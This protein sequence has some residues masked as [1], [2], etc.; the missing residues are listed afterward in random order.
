MTLLKKMQADAATY[1]P[2]DIG[3][4][5]VDALSGKTFT[6][7]NPATGVAL[8]EVAEGDALD[9]EAAVAAAEKAA[10]IWGA[11][12]PLQRAEI[13]NRAADI[14]K[15][16]MPEFVEV[17]V[18]QTG[19]PVREMKAQLARTPEWYSYFA[20]VAR[21][22]ETSSPPFGGHYLNY[23]RRMPIGVVG[24]VTPWN[25]PLLILTKKLAPALAAGN[26]VVVKPSE[27]APITPMMLADVLRDA[28]LPDG[29]YNVVPGFG[30]TAG[31]ALCNHDRIGKLD[32][33][34]G[35]ETGRMVAAIAGEKLIPFS[36]ELGGKASVIV[37][38]DVLESDA[39]AAALFASF[40]AAGQTCVQGARLLVQ[41]SVHDKVLDILVERA[42][43]LRIG[44]PTD[45]ATQMGPMVSA[46]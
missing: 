30:P 34:G 46:K 35:T 31:A 24:L 26:A 27:V 3:G 17:E 4:R 11:M 40:I 23:T 21:T 43:S 28:G 33:T 1:L 10:P 6:V 15:E 32:L 29:V 39:A 18:A 14:L 38:D 20:A 42:A 9:I 16:R 22:Y 19:R 25:H 37:F 2:L 5:K 8:C 41:K 7:I 12:S 45:F 13:L 44:D 36:G